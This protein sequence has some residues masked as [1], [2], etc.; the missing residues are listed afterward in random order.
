MTRRLATLA[1]AGL[2]LFI[3]SVP[4]SAGS[5]DDVPVYVVSTG[6]AA[7]FYGYVAPVVVTEKGGSVTYLNLDIARHDLVQDVQ[8]DGFAGSRKKPWCK[9]FRKGTCPVFWTPSIGLGQQ[10]QVKGL[11]SVKPGKTYSFLCTLHPGMTGTLIV[12]P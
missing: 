10:T 8:A 2:M 7:Q 11:E 6:P 1:L 9:S 5:T 3:I 4:T 12:R